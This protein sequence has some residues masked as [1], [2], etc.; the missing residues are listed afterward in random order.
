MNNIGRGPPKDHS[1]KNVDAQHMMDNIWRWNK[2]QLPG[3]LKHYTYLL[4]Q[5]TV[6]D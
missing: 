1:C 2:D 5:P 4:M 6:A 3:E